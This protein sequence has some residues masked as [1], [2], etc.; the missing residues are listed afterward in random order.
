MALTGRPTVQTLAALAVVFL[1]QQLAGLFGALEGIL[2]V[3]YG[4]VGDR[5]W[6]LV[7]S[8]YAHADLP[9]LLGNA[10]AL[11]VVG[12]LVARRT[13]TLRFHIFFVVTGAL[14]GVG[15][16][17]VGGLLGPPRGVLGASGAVLALLGYLLAGNA[18]STRLLDRLTLSPRAQL[19]VFGTVVIG[20][21]LATSGPGS[22]VLGHATG[23]AIGLAAG[24]LRLLDTRAGR[25][26]R[27]DSDSSGFA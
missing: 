17:V 4:P 8:V 26:G 10:I 18:V 27:R 20:L 12:P 1:L 9:H 21:T 19:V 14:A 5:P 23:L 3:L 2:F 15:E 16:I 7:T 22:A 25:A 6:A 24:R 11:A 13:T